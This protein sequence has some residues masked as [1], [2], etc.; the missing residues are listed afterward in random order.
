MAKKK[1][2]A[3]FKINLHAGEAT[4]APPV[5]PVLGQ[6]GINIVEFCRQ[7]NEKSIGDKGFIIPAIVTVYEDRSFNFKLKT[8][9]TADL[10]R[11]AAGVDKGSGTPNKIKVGSIS[12]EKVREIAEKKLSDLNTTDIE[13]AIKTITGTAKNMGIEI[14]DLK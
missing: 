8:P 1:I 14:L 10:L 11:K 5:G 2:K 9:P 12:K 6:H 4:P 3:S 13:A 7:Y